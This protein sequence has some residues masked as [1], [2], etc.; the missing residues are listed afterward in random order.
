LIKNCFTHSR[1]IG[2]KSEYKLI[3]KG[4]KT[5]DDCIKNHHDLPL[6]NQLKKKFL[7]TLDESIVQLK[8][9]NINYFIQ[10]FPTSEHWRILHHYFDEA[11]F[12]DIE[13][14][15]LSTFNNHV[16]VISAFKNKRLHT[17]VF[18][19]NLDEFLDFL[20]D[21]N[22]L[23]S[24]NGNSFDIPFLENTFN[25]PEIGCPHVDLRWIAYYFGFS[26]GLKNIERILGIQRPHELTDV[27]GSEAVLLY[28]L[29]RK[30]DTSALN[31]LLKYCQVD[32][33]TTY[34]VSCMILNQVDKNIKVPDIS[35]LFGTIDNL[36]RF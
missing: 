24:F 20:D 15:G 17:F 16:T 36:P 34:A 8:S 12:F 3:K 23:V 30:G 31:T 7:Q 28:N 32:V 35:L 4:F 19:E 22:L 25:L 33:L 18:D 27:D 5:W 26:G 13:T 6:S 1:G 29:Y 9:N 21:V 14:T 10:E 2:P 11:V